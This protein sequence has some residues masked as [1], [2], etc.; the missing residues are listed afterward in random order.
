MY[1]GLLRPKRDRLLCARRPYS[2]GNV[3]TCVRIPPPYLYVSTSWE[4]RSYTA[5][6]GMRRNV[7][8]FRGGLVFKAHRLLHHST[9][10]SRVITKRKKYALTVAAPAR[11]IS[12]HF[13]PSL[14]ALS[15]RSE[16]TRSI[17]IHLLI[18]LGGT[19]TPSFRRSALEATQGQIDSF[20]CQLPSTCH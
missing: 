18:S 4:S 10:G 9:L 15:L 8:R 1:L 17:K 13:E 20:F 12:D 5:Q 16:V 3:T 19:R 11:K 7:K 14:D 2:P 6:G